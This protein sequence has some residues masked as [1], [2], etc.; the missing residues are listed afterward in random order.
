MEKLENEMWQ[1]I[2]SMHLKHDHKMAIKQGI[3]LKSSNP[4]YMAAIGSTLQTI[5]LLHVWLFFFPC[6]C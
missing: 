1:I 3:K 2:L 6:Q 4:S 5:T